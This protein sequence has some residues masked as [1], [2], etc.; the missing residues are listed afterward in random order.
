[1]KESLRKYVKDMR[2]ELDMVTISA[3]L[4]D[5]L[6]GTDTYKNAKNVMLFYPLSDEVNL[7]SLLD[8]RTKNFYLPRIKG[9]ELECCKYA[10]GDELCES[11]FHTLE[12]VCASC[13]LS[14]I[15]II[16]VPALACD[17]NGYRLGYG[18]GFYDRLLKNYAGIKVCC[19]PKELLLDDIYP[20]EYDI[21]MD[22]V[23]LS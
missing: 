8:D 21:K 3:I 12:P 15:D 1:M 13:N 19:I 6:A 2:K 22:F 10:K 14:D 5:K 23:I 4:A 17:K 9:Q 16:I 7:L 11:C 18:G 20:K